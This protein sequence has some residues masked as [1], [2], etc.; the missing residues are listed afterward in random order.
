MPR[1]AYI[2]YT[3]PAAYPPL[4][5]S[6]RILAEKDWKVLFLGTGHST[7]SSFNFPSHPNIRV[8][9]LL[10]CP[11][12]WRQ[13]VHYLW[14]CIW[15]TVSLAVWKPRWIYAS[16][17]LS[18]PLGFFLSLLFE[19]RMIYHEHDSPPSENRAKPPSYPTKFIL[20]AR[21]K[22]GRRAVVCI[23]PNEERTS[24][25]AVEVNPKGDI[26]TVKNCPSRKETGPPRSA[27]TDADLWMLY[28][29]SLVAERLPLSVPE[30]MVFLPASVKLRVIG[31]ETVGD[32]GYLKRL[33][34]AAVRFGVVQRIEILGAMP[35][36]K[37]VLEYALQCDVGLSFVPLESADVNLQ[38]MAGASNKPFEYL[39]C[40]LA[41]LV[42]DL[43]DWRR[44]YVEPGYG[45]ACD[46]SD[47]NSIA[48]AI[49][50]FLEH[51]P[52]MQ[53]M[54]ERGRQRIL[55]EWNYEA[56]F[57]PILERL[58]ESTTPDHQRG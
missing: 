56:Q 21:K 53:Q 49:R 36:R 4:E 8:K 19:F 47:P 43:P 40:G 10:F 1:I 30:A 24:R 18:C 25:F 34:E 38:Q 2:Q 45:L 31:Y 9:R 13:K 26:R 15:A 28:H 12:G 46:P 17:P 7:G 11:A 44:I 14:F 27:K 48:R 33:R 16:D 5:H 52:Q 51:F 32:D 6:S 57:Q 39:A 58:H 54:G 42:S 29:G 23:L 20:W 3:N 41:L 55:Q 35:S 37:E 22:L 50:W